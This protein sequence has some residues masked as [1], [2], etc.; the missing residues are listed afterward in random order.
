MSDEEL[1]AG[2]QERSLAHAEWTHRAHVRVA[3]MHLARWEL[4]EAHLRMRAGIIRLNAVH[5][6]EETTKRGYHETLTRTWLAIV[7]AVRRVDPGATSLE[8]VTRHAD[9]LD[10]N[11]PLFHYSSARLFSHEARSIFVPPDLASLP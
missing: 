2:F 8:F 7:Q 9:A 1:W 3:W 11:A 5:G 10:R 6:T 4:D